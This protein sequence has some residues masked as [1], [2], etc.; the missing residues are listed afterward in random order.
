MND[1]ELDTEQ[2]ALYEQLIS[3]IEYKS[4]TKIEAERI[5]EILDSLIDKLLK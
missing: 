5:I 3:Y 1:K 4:Y 2:L